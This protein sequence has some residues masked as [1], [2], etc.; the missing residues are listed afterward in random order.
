MSTKITTKKRIQGDIRLKELSAWRRQMQQD[1]FDKLW[2][3]I[4]WVIRRHMQQPKTDDFLTG[5][6]IVPGAVAD[7]TTPNITTDDTADIEGVK[8]LERL[9]KE[10]G[11]DV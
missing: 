8:A 7:I 1:G 9:L 10:E 11:R 2:T 5:L 3:W 6:G 4:C